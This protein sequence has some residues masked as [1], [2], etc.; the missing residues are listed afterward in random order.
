MAKRRAK[1]PLL[2]VPEVADEF[3][4]SQR[5]VRRLIAERRIDFVRLGRHVRIKESVV[6]ATIEA[7]TVEAI[8]RRSRGRGRVVA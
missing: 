3:G 8:D 1:D 4:T 6:R 2:S 5:F 7:G